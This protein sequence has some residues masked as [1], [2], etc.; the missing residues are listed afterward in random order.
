VS[1]DFVRTG[2]SYMHSCRA[3]PFALVGFSCLEHAIICNNY[4]STVENSQ[5]ARRTRLQY[6]LIPSLHDQAGSTSCYMLVGRASL[7]FAQRLLDHV[8]R[9]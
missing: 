5:R 8:N 2:L 6:S 4:R 3:F 7:M 1:L 9:V